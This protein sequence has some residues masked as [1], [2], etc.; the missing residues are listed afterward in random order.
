VLSRISRAGW[1]LGGSCKSVTM[2]VVSRVFPLAMK[3][4][5]TRGCF[6]ASV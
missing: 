2:R 1:E 4:Y 3:L 5:D 6:S